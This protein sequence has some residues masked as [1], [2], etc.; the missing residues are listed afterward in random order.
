MVKSKQEMNNNATFPGL[1]EIDEFD[2]QTE[3][4]MNYY[5]GIA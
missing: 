5:Y 4:N 2:D 1:V 3:K